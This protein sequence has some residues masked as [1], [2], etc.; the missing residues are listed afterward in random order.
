MNPCDDIVEFAGI[1]GCTR[2]IAC[3]GR[4]RRRT[5]VARH[6]YERCRSS[7]A[8]CGGVPAIRVLVLVGSGRGR[9][10]NCP[11]WRAR[12]ITVLAMRYDDRRDIRRY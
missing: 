12:A 11:G 5:R 1:G 4:W 2:L 8:E 7:R 6:E 10:K 9:G 3:G